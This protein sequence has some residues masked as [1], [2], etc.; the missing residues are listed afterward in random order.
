MGFYAPDALVHEAQRRG[1]TVVAPDVNA[2]AV[3]CTVLPPRGP[4]DPPPGIR[5]GLGRILGVR[6][7]EIAALVAERERG[8]PFSSLVDLASRAGAG[9]PAL[10]QLAWSGAC[11]ALAGGDR[12]RV[13]WEL[14]VASPG[15]RL[16][17]G[18]GTQLA[19]ALDTGPAPALAALGDRDRMVADYATTGLTTGPH[20]LALERDRLAARG[21]ASTADLPAIADRESLWI[22]GLVLA[23]QRPSTASGVCFVLI[24]DEHGTANL[25]L[26]PAVYDRHRAIVRT[27]P[28]LV[29]AGILERHPAAGGGVNILCHALERYER[30]GLTATTTTLHSGEPE[31]DPQLSDF[32]AVAP[33]IQSFATGRRR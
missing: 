12:R 28:L 15:R 2:S 18:A 32:R 16:P 23:R 10:E 29:A 17:G 3:E 31:P 27:E 24:E 26:P 8:G 33:P 22:A 14:G 5:L 20:P 30:A 19:L 9:R 6:E 21:V 13:F 7:D 4:G 11:D 25:I 1:L